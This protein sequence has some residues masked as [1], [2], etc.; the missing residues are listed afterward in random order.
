MWTQVRRPPKLF[1]GECAVV[2]A[3]NDDY[4]LFNVDGRLYSTSNRCPHQ[5]GSLGE[6]YLEGSCVVC[7]LHGWGFDVRTGQPAYVAQPGHVRTYAVKEEN[8]EVWL[9]L[10]EI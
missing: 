8:G 7:P 4:A 3:G 6:G 1:P 5:G 10:P 9:D 2:R